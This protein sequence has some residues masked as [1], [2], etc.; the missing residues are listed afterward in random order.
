M[1]MG[2]WVLFRV[3]PTDGLPVTY[4]VHQKMTY[5]GAPV[6]LDC[7]W[8]PIQIERENALRQKVPLNIGWRWQVVLLLE[9][10]GTFQQFDEDSRFVATL[11]EA[12]REDSTQVEMSTDGGQTWIA[13]V[14]RKSRRDLRGKKPHIG[15]IHRIELMSR[16]VLP[17]KPAE[18]ET[19]VTNFGQ[20]GDSGASL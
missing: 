8:E 14:Y 18:T 2:Y 16:D 9:L 4:D 5:L 1:G 10:G 17:R 19:I 3:T 6:A 12:L 11:L 7:E 20:W 15:A 13:V